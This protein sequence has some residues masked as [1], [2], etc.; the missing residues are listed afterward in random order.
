M[1]FS[2][3]SLSETERR[4]SLFGAFFSLDFQTVAIITYAGIGLRRKNYVVP[5][6]AQILSHHFVVYVVVMDVLRGSTPLGVEFWIP[7]KRQR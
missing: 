2:G 5:G 7:L 3:E 4:F 6:L 1:D